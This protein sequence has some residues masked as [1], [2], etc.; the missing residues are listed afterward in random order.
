[1]VPHSRTSA[2]NMNKTRKEQE[3]ESFEDAALYDE[4]MDR[5][6][7]QTL[8]AEVHRR[9]SSYSLQRA[10][11]LEIGAG[12]SEFIND[13]PEDSFVVL[14]DITHALLARNGQRGHPVVCDAECRPFRDGSF[15]FILFVGIL[16]HLPDQQR[17]LEESRR[18]LSPHGEGILV[19]EPHRRSINFL[20]HYSRRVIQAVFGTGLIKRL[21]GCF[22]PAE[23]QVDLRAISSVFGHGFR[24]RKKTF[25]SVRLPPF[26]FLSKSDLDA[27]L[28]R[29][30]DPLPVLRDVGTTVLLEISP[31][32]RQTGLLRGSSRSLD[33][34]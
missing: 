12:V 14:T 17:A 6:Y 20:Y 3:I 28:S 18:L 31:A 32:D 27:R 30:L 4:L 8:K 1:M 21:I 9:L 23:S 11:V 34:A 2:E 22:S 29:V 15:E 26:R 19:C 33:S 7:T 24:I 5:P 16:H 10:R 25:L 13:F